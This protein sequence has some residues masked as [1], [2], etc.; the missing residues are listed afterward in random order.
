MTD[1]PWTLTGT[2]HEP[3][4]HTTDTGRGG[5]C[6]LLNEPVISILKGADMAT[7]IRITIVFWHDTSPR[8]GGLSLNPA[9]YRKPRVTV[10][11][12]T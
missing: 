5:H 4:G 8:A 9:D 12:A 10:G 1:I 6:R 2:I 7:T 11:G 3:R